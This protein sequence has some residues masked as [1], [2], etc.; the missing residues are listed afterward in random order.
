[1][2]RVMLSIAKHFAWLIYKYRH[3]K[4]TGNC[5]RW[6][7]HCSA[8][9]TGRDFSGTQVSPSSSPPRIDN[10]SDFYR[11]WGGLSGSKGCDFSTLRHPILKKRGLKDRCPPRINDSKRSPFH[12]RTS[13]G[14]GKQQWQCHVVKRVASILGGLK[15]PCL[16]IQTASTWVHGIF[17]LYLFITKSELRPFVLQ[18]R[19]QELLGEFPTQPLSPH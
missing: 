2:P 18:H 1:M 12:P 3:S 14:G 16:S 9:E 13:E 7:S 17:L 15:T 8:W 5:S 4:T 11:C 19:S 10:A 6:T